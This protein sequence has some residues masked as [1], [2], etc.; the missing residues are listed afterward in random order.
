METTLL[1]VTGNAKLDHYLAIVGIVST[2]A[3]TLASALNAKVR[4]VLD[5][6]D[7]V[8]T[9]FLYLALAANYAALNVD[10]AA[11]VHKLLKGGTVIVTKVGAAKADEEVA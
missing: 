8:P 3:S 1:P 6:G 11:Q 7:E 4:A 10:K 2:V 9:A 5:A